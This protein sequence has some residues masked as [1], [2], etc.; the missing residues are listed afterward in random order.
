MKYNSD[1]Y[2]VHL[3]TNNVYL[4]TNKQYSEEELLSSFYDY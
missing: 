4:Q 2:N 1:K 3:P